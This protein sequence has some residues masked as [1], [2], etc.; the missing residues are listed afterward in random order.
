MTRF[1][2]VE[3]F[4]DVSRAY[5]ADR[6]R[7]RRLGYVEATMGVL[8]KDGAG[9]GGF[10][11]EF[12]GYGPG[13]VRAVADPVPLCD[14][15]I[16]GPL[17]VWREMLENIASNGAADL[18]HTLNRLTMAGVPLRVLSQDQLRQDLFFRFN[19]SFQAFFDASA[20]V[21]TQFPALAPA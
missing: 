13:S 19:Q 15:T 7:V 21:Q 2:S 11:L 9:S 8:V 16:A 1:P 20:A 18:D 10:V 4:D 5:S 17:Q 12:S 3:W 6:E 14:F